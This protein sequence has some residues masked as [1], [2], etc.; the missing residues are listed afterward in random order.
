MKYLIS[1]IRICLRCFN[2]LQANSGEWL[3][4]FTELILTTKSI[5]VINNFP[6]NQPD[7]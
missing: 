5:H 7:N 2:A 6:F 1:R 4:V 3:T